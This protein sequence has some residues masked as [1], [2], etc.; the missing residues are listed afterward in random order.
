MDLLITVWALATT[1]LLPARLAPK[2]MAAVHDGTRTRTWRVG[3]VMFYAGILIWSP[4][5]LIRKLLAFPVSSRPFLAFHF[6]S[7]YGGLL[8]QWLGKAK[9]PPAPVGADGGPGA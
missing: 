3:K 5:A 7:L 4:Y 1:F 8:L 2:V 6:V 9:P